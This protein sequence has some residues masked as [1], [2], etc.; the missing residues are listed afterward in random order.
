MLRFPVTHSTLSGPALAEAL[1]RLYALDPIH[2]CVL[3]ERHM[4][5][6]YLVRT[7]GARHILRLYRCGVRSREAIGYELDL[8]DH[9]AARGVLV[10]T[11]IA[12]R[13]GERIHEVAAPEGPRF[14]A[15]FRFATGSPAPLTPPAM[16]RYGQA[17]AA[18]HR[19]GEGFVSPH[20]RPPLDLDL[21]VHRSIARLEPWL[22]RAPADGLFVA[23]LL[24]TLAQ[25]LAR[26]VRDG[27]GVGVCHGDCHEANVHLDA[28]R[29]TFFDFDLCGPGWPA[30]DLAVVRDRIQQTG[31]PISVWESFLAG[32][33]ETRPL[34]RAEVDAIPWLVVARNLF[35][36]QGV[37]EHAGS[38][39]LGLHFADGRY[40]ADL[41]RYLRLWATAAN[42][43]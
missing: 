30:F 32:Y 42:L 10:A 37:L 35:V 40:A 2:E 12:D 22:V 13:A 20:Q 3:L 9:L 28:G 17:L 4:H 15:L 14:L 29:F 24:E 18:L 38:W 33:Q 5:D 25:A 23:R 21:L 43:L 1:G 26:L 16:R 8:L 34:G 27:L 31:S 19:A 41:V 7:A 6:T 36:A 39:G 11:P